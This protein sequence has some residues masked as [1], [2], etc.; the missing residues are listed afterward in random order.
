MA[1]LDKHLRPTAKFLG[2]PR[3]AS[4]N[5]NWLVFELASRML[6]RKWVSIIGEKERLRKGDFVAAR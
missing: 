3:C 6:A 4:K 1:L 5:K 2:V